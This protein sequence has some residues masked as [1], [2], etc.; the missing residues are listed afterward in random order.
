MSDQTRIHPSISCKSIAAA[1]RPYEGNLGL[2]RRAHG[3][4]MIM[5]FFLLLLLSAPPAVAQGSVAAAHESRLGARPASSLPNTMGGGDQATVRPV[6]ARASISHVSFEKF[7]VPIGKEPPLEGGVWYPARDERSTQT[8]P[9]PV[10]TE[11]ARVGGNRLPLIVISHGGG[12]SY[13]AH[14]DTA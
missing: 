6:A 9:S 10:V 11:N 2:R 8:S 7:E 14:S 13:A 12:A 1:A 4:G 3:I 5:A